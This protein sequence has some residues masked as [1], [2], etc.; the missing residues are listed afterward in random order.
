MSAPCRDCGGTKDVVAKGVVYCTP[1]RKVR[2]AIAEEKPR[3]RPKKRATPCMGCGGPKDRGIRGA[4]Y[5]EACYEVKRPVWEQMERERCKTKNEKSRREQGIK[6]RV[7][8]LREED[9]YVWCGKCL[10]Y[11]PPG[12]FAKATGQKCGRA[13]YCKPCAYAY[14]HERRLLTQFG[15]SYQE[16][17]RISEV[18][19]GRC[20]I[21]RNRPRSKRL[22]VDHNHATGEVRGLL[23]KRCNRDLLGAAQDSIEMLERAICYLESPPARTGVPVA[24]HEEFEELPGPPKVHNHQR[25]EQDGRRRENREATA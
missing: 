18:Q 10:R 4:R 15:I 17:L 16:Y 11:L 5:C 8:R 13:P 21:C 14:N 3:E 23:C 19:D 1:C 25:V 6:L 22:A 7:T 24:I 2:A 9:G 20:A 12:R